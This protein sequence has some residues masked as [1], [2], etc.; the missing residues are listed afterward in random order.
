MSIGNGAPAWPS[1]IVSNGGISPSDHIRTQLGA[2]RTPVV[3]A[4]YALRRSDVHTSKGNPS[5]EGGVVT[6]SSNAWWYAA[7]ARAGRPDRGASCS[8]AIP[9]LAY[10]RIQERTVSTSR[11]LQRAISV[12]LCPRLTAFTISSRSR[13][14][15]ERSRRRKILSISFCSSS[16]IVITCAPPLSSRIEQDQRTYQRL[17]S[18]IRVVQPG[19]V[20]WW[21][22]PRPKPPGRRCSAC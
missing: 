21:L 14:R 8:A 5:A 19:C 6:A 17:L 16:L 20:P 4:R 1:V 18:R 22:Y 13:C 11:P 9:P 2:I 3:S 15:G 7:S 12:A 10:R